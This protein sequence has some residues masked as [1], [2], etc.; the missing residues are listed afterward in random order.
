MRSDHK[1]YYVRY[2][3]RHFMLGFQYNFDHPDAFDPELLKD[4]IIR[5]KEM[6]KVD[7]PIYNFVKHARETKT[8]SMYG[9]NVII[10]E[11]L[12]AFHNEEIRDMLDMKV[13]C[14]FV[15]F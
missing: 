3:G 10:F 12:F 9:A 15:D 5:L 11:G 4:T 7:V 1:L 8:V 13:C 14:C 2:A 6:K